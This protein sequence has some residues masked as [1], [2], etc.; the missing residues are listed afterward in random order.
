MRLYVA[1]SWRNP[2]QAE[3]VQALRKAGH[4]VY[5]FRHP[6]P[7]DEGFDWADI[8]PNWQDQNADQFRKALEHPSAQQGFK[9]DMDALV[10]CDGC[11]LV[12][13]CN[14]S[15]HLELGY[16]VGA[17]KF[18]VILLEN[19]EPELMY[20]MADRLAVSIE[21]LLA[22]FDPNQWLEGGDVR[23]A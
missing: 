7:G 13:P 18:T 5:D 22:V 17:G 12:M 4:L 9:L 8:D 19:G 21:E 6:R 14:R 15:A 2:K 1:S 10:T 11:V 16:A 3:V 20:L 23:D